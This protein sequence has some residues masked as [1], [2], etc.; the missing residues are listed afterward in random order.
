MQLTHLVLGL[1]WLVDII[2]NIDNKKIVT[3]YF[4]RQVVVWSHMLQ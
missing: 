3:K 4:C 1:R 2:E